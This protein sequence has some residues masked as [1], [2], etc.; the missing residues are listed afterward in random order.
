MDE[1]IIDRLKGIVGEDNVSM[2][3]VDL[4]CYSKDSY[5]VGKGVFPDIVLRPGSIEE[6]S[7]IMSIAYE[8]EIHVS[9]GVQVHVSPGD[10]FP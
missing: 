9:P 8:N 1:R 3:P 10:A 6:I 2:D 7:K 5:A 4:V